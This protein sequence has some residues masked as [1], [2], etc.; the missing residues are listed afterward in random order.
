MASRS[1]LGSGQP[2]SVTLVHDDVGMIGPRP[3]MPSWPA[4]FVPRTKV[5]HMTA[6]DQRPELQKT[7]APQ[8]SS[9]H[10]AGW[11]EAVVP[12]LPKAERTNQSA[13][14]RITT[15]NLVRL[16]H[17]AVQDKDLYAN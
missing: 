7:L 10:D 16:A 6:P 3:R 5:V 12:K 15:E 1:R 17:P 2:V 14:V 9:T 11:Q 8:G 4:A 13:G